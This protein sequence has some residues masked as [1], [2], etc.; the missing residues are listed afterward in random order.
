QMTQIEKVDKNV[1]SY[2]YLKLVDRLIKEQISRNVKLS[3][4]FYPATILAAGLLVGF[5]EGR[6]RVIGKLLV[7][8]PDLILIFGVPL[9][10]I[11]GIL[12]LAIL[13]AVF[14]GKIYKKEL[15]MMYG[16]EFK[17]LEE[18]IADLEELRSVS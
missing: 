17:K 4:F 9:Y 5:S 8:F 3:R 2:Q 7:K 15:C 1:S 14:A 13:M 12:L 10:F 18:I 11:L 16:R 6:E